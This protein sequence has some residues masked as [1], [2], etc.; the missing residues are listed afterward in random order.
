MGEVVHLEP[1][2]RMCR[3][4]T[5]WRQL[6]LYGAAQPEGRCEKRPRMS[7]SDLW[8][9]ELDEREATNSDWHCPLWEKK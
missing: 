4:C 3:N 2:N 6:M 5:H 8:Y 7:D 9:Y 1:V